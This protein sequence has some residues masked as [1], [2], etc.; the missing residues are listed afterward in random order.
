MKREYE[1]LLPDE[2]AAIAKARRLAAEEGRAHQGRSAFLS[3]ASSR[4][5]VASLGG[6]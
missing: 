1:V 4:T 6:G 3:L 5:T 2:G